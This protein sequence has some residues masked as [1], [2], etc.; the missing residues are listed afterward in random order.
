[1][2]YH[3]EKMAAF[4]VMGKASKQFI[5]SVQA[6]SFWKQCGEDGVLKTLT[7]CSSSPRRE[8]IGIADGSS[9]D[10]ESYLYYICTPFA[11][12]E[13][14]DGYVVKEIPERLWAKFRCRDLGAEN[15]ADSDLW[16]RIY[17]EFFPASNY[18][19]GEYQLEV[20]PQG[21]GDYPDDIS[22]AWI[23]VHEKAKTL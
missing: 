9:Y 3:V 16:N 13:I 7:A 21:D 8:Y 17:S 22:E 18:M 23:A 6:N 12:G 14:P 11:D 15:T 20:Y 2:D 4:K 1:M 19:P 5:D 10:G